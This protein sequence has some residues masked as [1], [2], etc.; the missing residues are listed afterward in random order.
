M[1]LSENS[2][3]P[4]LL[5][6][7]KDKQ[8]VERF[9]AWL[10]ANPQA[11]NAEVMLVHVLEPNWFNDIPYSPLSAMRLLDQQD[12]VT[13]EVQREFDALTGS[14]QKRFPDSLIS[15]L[16]VTK[17]SDTGTAIVDVAKEWH[18]NC[19]LMFCS[20]KSPI[21]E[22]LCGRLSTRIL[23]SA[24]CAV[25]VIQRPD[26]QHASPNRFRFPPRGRFD[27]PI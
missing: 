11:W 23:R 10:S 20:S 1:L 15:A 21:R 17:V 9:C 13:A 27:L 6:P 19:I 4:K 8:C 14:V 24:S 26:E 25:Q 7:V 5:V 2:V 22:L 16:V 18:A 3:K 12:Q